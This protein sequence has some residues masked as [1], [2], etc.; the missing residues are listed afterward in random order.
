MWNS[1][2]SRE[3]HDLIQLTRDF[4][5]REVVP[6]AAELDSRPSPEECFSWEMVE[7]ASAVGLRTLALEEAYGGAGADFLT[8]AMVIEEM[9]KGDMGF[10]VVFA[11]TWKLVQ[12]LQLAGTAE[13]KHRFLPAFRDD[14]RYLLAITLTEPDTASDYIVPFA[15]A[16]YR[17]TATRA[18]GGWRLSGFK[19]FISN[20]NR[21]ALYIV[22]AQTDPSRPLT[23]GSTAFL[24]PRG[25]PGLSV[26]RVHDKLGERLANN[27]E[28]IF[29]D[30]FVPDGD[31]LG[32][33]DGGYTVQSLFF[34]ASNAYAAATVLGAAEAA[35][36]RATLWARQR[37]QG[38][39]PI[40][41]HDSVV[42]DLAEM[43]MWLDATRLYVYHAAWAGG[44]REAWDGT[45]GALPK[46][47]ASQVAWQVVTRA[48]EIHG[49][50]GFMKET[51]MEKLLR[52]VAAF[53]HSDGVNR[54]LLLKA[55]R[56][57]R[58]GG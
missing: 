57:L 25:A 51:G 14:P 8:T 15:E 56:F 28:V 22:F 46:V 55:G 39:R 3:Q 58:E 42:S 43:R 53:L 11:Q 40:I 16:R 23:E 36:E 50:Y 49:G 45:L 19:H 27:A 30:C 47:L 5:R 6:R 24:V 26:G 54:S 44:H 13:Q 29:K 31:V 17:T 12:T 20:G 2:P 10:A 34:P 48:M 32:E 33:V 9:A 21:A 4:M 35:H 52:D 18:V 37:V 38:G 41:G 1:A 7:R